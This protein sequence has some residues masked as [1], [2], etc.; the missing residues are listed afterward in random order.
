MVHKLEV[1]SEDGKY[2]AL[3]DGSA[4]EKSVYLPRDNHE[5]ALAC[6]NGDYSIS[7]QINTPLKDVPYCDVLYGITQMSKENQM[8]EE[9]VYTDDLE[10]K[11]ENLT[12]GETLAITRIIGVLS[13]M[14]EVEKRYKRKLREIE[15]TLRDC[16]QTLNR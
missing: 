13:Y 2:S 5:M 7:K 16:L 1:I 9:E 15:K 4:L 6:S 14:L 3:L 8:G 10:I 12:E 11:T